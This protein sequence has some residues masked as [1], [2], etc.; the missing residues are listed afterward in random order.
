[1]TEKEMNHLVSMITEQVLCLLKSQGR[2]D[3][4]DTDTGKDRVLVISN[5]RT[6][7]P[8]ELIQNAVVFHMDDYKRSQNILQYSRVII[9]SLNM[10][11]L[12]DIAL[13]RNSDAVTCAVLHALLNGIDVYLLENA[14]KYR[15]F[16]GKGSTALYALLENYTTTLQ[17]F[18]VKLVSAKAQVTAVREAKPAKFFQP[19]VKVPKGSAVPNSQLLITEAD[20]LAMVAGDEPFKIPEGAILTPSARDVLE[21]N[22]R[23]SES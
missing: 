20:A 12:A 8:E 23:F 4:D 6:D 21:H 1:M 17:V 14:L 9:A 18:G 7:V 11:E 5:G 15:K 3:L 2:E 19:S 22:R 13:G 10:T 16:A